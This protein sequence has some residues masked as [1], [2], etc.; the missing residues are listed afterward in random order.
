MQIIK[1]HTKFDFVGRIKIYGS[2][3][4]GLMILAIIGMLVRGFNWGI[5]FAGGT[6]LQVRFDQDVKAA[7]LRQ[8][9]V[10]MGFKKN[11]VQNYGDPEDHEYLLRIERITSLTTARVDRLREAAIKKFGA[12]RLHEVIFVPREGDHLVMNF[13]LPK[14]AAAPVLAEDAGVNED[15]GAQQSAPAAAPSKEEQL[16]KK[17]AQTEKAIAGLKQEVHD[18]FAAEKIDLRPNDPIEAGSPRSGRVE[19]TV[20]F[21]GVSGR[22]V[23]ALTQRFGVACTADNAATVCSNTKTCDDGHCK[24]DNRRTDYVDSNV[25]KELRTDG[26]LAIIYALIGILIYIAVRFDF[27]F[28]PGAVVALVHD[29]T[30]T[31]GIF[32][33]TGMEFDLTVVAALLT[34]VGYSLNDT[35]VVYDRIRETMPSEDKVKESERGG[36]VNQAINDTLSRTLLTSITTMLVIV[37]LLIFATGVIKTF[38]I[39]MAIGVTVGT[40]SSVFVASPVYL[41]L[42][43]WMPSNEH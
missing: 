17:A 36:Y 9:L 34:I 12:E 25:S 16:K 2:I 13:S 18:F 40:Y 8:S 6:E 27:Y 37:A 32:A 33:W 24:V 1:P 43:K 35:I 26:L 38:G 22:I 5:D 42:R 14:L 29:V 31:M 41:I 7:D 19:L 30:I 28:S 11:Q 39:A 10:D 4:A 15:G 20:H 3:S 23:Q 21:K